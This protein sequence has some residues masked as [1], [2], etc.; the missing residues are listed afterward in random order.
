VH[1]TNDISKLEADL[2]EAADNLRA[3]S[4]LMS[5]DYLMRVLGVIFLRQ[6]ADHVR[7]RALWLPEN[8][9]FDNIMEHTPVGRGAHL[10]KRVTEAMEAIEAEFEPLRG[11]LPNDYDYVWQRSSTGAEWMAAQN[12]VHPDGRVRRE[13]SRTVESMRPA[14]HEP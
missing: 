14:R 13:R 7:Q 2:W 1:G 5:S 6:P 11:V 12:S 10:P 9:R 4:K 3:N 8:A